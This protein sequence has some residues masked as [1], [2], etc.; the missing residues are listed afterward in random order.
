MCASVA[1][2]NEALP[3]VKLASDH[4]LRQ[5]AA[6]SGSEGLA[7]REMEGRYDGATV[8][9]EEGGSGGPVLQLLRADVQRRHDSWSAGDEEGGEPTVAWQHCNRSMRL[10][11]P[12]AEPSSI[13]GKA[14]RTDGP[15]VTC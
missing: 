7:R 5:A 8:C 2:G 12:P 1:G 9:S 14:Q 13:D 10:K 15:R 4:Q 3:R 6:A 11:P